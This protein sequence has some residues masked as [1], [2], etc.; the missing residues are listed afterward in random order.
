[1][2]SPEKRT[3]GGRTEQ[4]TIDGRTKVGGTEIEAV[5][6]DDDRDVIGWIVP[7]TIGNDFVVPH[8]W[9]E[10]RADEL[11]L[12]PRLLP[13]KTSAK[14]AFTRAGNRTDTREIVEL[15]RKEN[16]DIHL[17]K[18][19][20][21]RRFH[22]EIHDRR[23]EG[24]FDG[25]VIGVIEYEDGLNGRPK[26]EPG[27]EAWDIWNEYV[28]AFKDEFELM[29][30]SVLGEDI[31]HMITKVFRD[32]SWSVKF[33]AGGGVYFAPPAIKDVVSGIDQLISDIDREHKVSGF[34]CELDT[35]EV[36]DSS[37][38][39]SMVED[40]VRRDLER[41]VAEIIE[42]AFEELAD[43]EALVDD[44]K[45]T[46]EDELSDVEDFAVEYNALLDAEMSVRDHLEE[47]KEEATGQAEDLVDEML[48]SDGLEAEDDD[49]EEEEATD[50][51]RVI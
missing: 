24:E 33:R 28:E 26:V 36:A 50:E 9:L 45:G 10:A 16:V 35:I 11:G 19:R 29:K 46:I 49:D 12:S 8:D 38:K 5:T 14:R 31:R 42:D 2:S 21:E 47:W 15:E 6:N 40:K 30:E 4:A 44:V 48:T 20:Y 22:L 25:D 13:S 3:D 7:F 43:D 17:E 51:D 32:Q 39:R 37:E 34:P 18:V 41:Q 1:M 27:D 23:E